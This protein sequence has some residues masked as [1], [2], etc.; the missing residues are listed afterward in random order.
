MV[1]D[2][3]PWYREMISVVGSLGS[4]SVVG[5]LASTCSG[6]GNIGMLPI[7]HALHVDP[8][9]LKCLNKIKLSW[10]FV[11]PVTQLS[12]IGMTSRR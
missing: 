5:K 6:V 12:S 9:V 2:N 7:S 1:A 10:E 11:E 3:L 8:S 4:L